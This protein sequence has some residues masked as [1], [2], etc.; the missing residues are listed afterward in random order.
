M[1]VSLH[2]SRIT[3]LAKNLAQ[4]STAA[5]GRLTAVMDEVYTLASSR[6]E[7]QLG[8]SGYGDYVA[9]FDGATFSRD[10]E[11]A[12]MAS[13]QR[14]LRMLESAEAYY[15]LYFFVLSLRE[16]QDKTVLLDVKRFGEGTLEPS[17][18]SSLMEMRDEYL[19]MG[20]N[21]C[22]QYGYSGTIQMGSV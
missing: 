21:I 16:L 1:A 12:A 18:I 20:D 11:F 3:V 7:K 22:S 8:S 15:L 9:L 13:G 6:M 19:K 14:K 10:T 5:I 17:E 2:L 4:L